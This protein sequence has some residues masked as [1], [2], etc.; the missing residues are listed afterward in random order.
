MREGE[1]R[2]HPPGPFTGPILQIDMARARW[3][4]FTK[5]ETIPGALEIITLP[6]SAPINRTTMRAVTDLAS[7]QGIIRTEN[8]KRHMAATGRRPYTSLRGAVNIEPTAR[9]IR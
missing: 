2:I 6:N 3:S 4:S 9:P 8:M 1:N 5:S 7:A